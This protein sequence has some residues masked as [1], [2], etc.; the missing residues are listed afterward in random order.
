MQ[1]SCHCTFFTAAVSFF[2]PCN[3]FS[4]PRTPRSRSPIGSEW[5]YHWSQDQEGRWYRVW[6]RATR[7]WLN[8]VCNNRT[9]TSSQPGGATWHNSESYKKCRQLFA[10]EAHTVSQ[11]NSFACLADLIGYNIR[12]SPQHATKCPNI[13]CHLH[14][15]LNFYSLLRLHEPRFGALCVWTSL[16]HEIRGS[17]PSCFWSANAACRSISLTLRGYRV[18]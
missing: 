4:M 12:I 2:S 18:S 1:D 10:H 8:S 13:T 3:A 9:T 15:H 5:R 14:C 16:E 17:Q 11:L 7:S 6:F